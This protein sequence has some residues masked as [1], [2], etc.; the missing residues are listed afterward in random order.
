M[1]E[2]EAQLRYR[3]GAIRQGW[4]QSFLLMNPWFHSRSLLVSLKHGYLRQQHI[5]MEHSQVGG[6]LALS[7][8]ACTYH[9]T[10][11]LRASLFPSLLQVS[12]S[13]SHLQRP[14]GWSDWPHGVF[15]GTRKHSA[16]LFSDVMRCDGMI[17]LFPY[18]H[19]YIHTYIC[20]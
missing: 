7:T 20:T 12:H 4:L 19:T 6:T 13:W 11:F 1:S 9:L 10:A 17:Q 16:G 18:I 14:H 2:P 3:A 8:L 15:H 5:R